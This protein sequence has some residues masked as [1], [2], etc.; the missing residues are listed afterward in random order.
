MNPTDSRI[1]RA[2][3]RAAD[4][5]VRNLALGKPATQSSVNPWFQA[6]TPELDAAMGNNGK[7]AGTYG[8]QTAFEKDPW[9][10]VDLNEGYM[11]GRVVVFNR[12]DQKE[13]CRHLSVLSSLDG[14]SWHLRGIKLDDDLFGG[15]DGNPYSYVFEP[16]FKARFIRVQL[17]GDGHL[18]LDE[19]EVYHE[20]AA[21]VTDA[22]TPAISGPAAVELSPEA[23]P[24][25]HTA[26]V[27]CAR[28]ETDFIEEWIT[29]Y[30][31]IGFE[32]VYL[33]CNDDDPDQLYD[34]VLTFVTGH[35]PFVTF[36]H[37]AGQGLQYEMYLHFIDKFLHEVR[38]VSFLDVDEFLRIADGSTIDKFLSRFDNEADCILFNWRI[39]GTSGHTKHPAGKVLENY[40]RCDRDINSFTKFICR[41]SLL[42]DRK[43]QNPDLGFG[44]WHSLYGKTYRPIKVVNVLGSTER[45]E[46][47]EGDEAD[48][49]LNTAV[50]HH[51]ILR[52]EDAAMMRVARGLQGAFSG[53]SIWDVSNA[54][55]RE[56]LTFYNDVEDLSLA[57]FWRNLAAK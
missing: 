50:L 39:F 16:P 34:K 37:F 33:Y 49:I 57:Y 52:S 13:A 24:L 28:W 4:A 30:Q 47:Y 10:Q 32:H 7:H 40:T 5:V 2:R 43:L 29:Y 1:I 41:A 48:S 51:Y 6:A 12:L 31:C 55:G 18:H 36:I 21:I 8:F 9:W 14:E 20:Q 44:F 46:K 22:A 56:A 45:K 42:L 23:T 35:L 25:Y 53:Q 38:W 19:I 54:R 27:V 11:I 3:A 15:A 17:I 26:V